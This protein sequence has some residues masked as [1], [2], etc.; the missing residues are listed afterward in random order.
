MPDIRQMLELIS[1]LYNGVLV[2]TDFKTTNGIGRNEIIFNSKS[3]FFNES[4]IC[5][6][7]V[8]I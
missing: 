7:K 8:R 6:N 4:S 2:I 3:D 5:I 1:K